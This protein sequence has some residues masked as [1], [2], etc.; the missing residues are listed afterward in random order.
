M[1]EADL[2]PSAGVSVVGEVW[3][4]DDAFANGKVVTVNLP[5]DAAPGEE[6]RFSISIAFWGGGECD[7]VDTLTAPQC[8]SPR[9]RSGDRTGHVSAAAEWRLDLS[10]TVRALR[11]LNSRAVVTRQH[12]IHERSVAGPAGRVDGHSAG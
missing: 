6:V 9:V 10:V 11:D 1:A 2:G 3:T 5:Y 12:V 4:S 8:G 7:A